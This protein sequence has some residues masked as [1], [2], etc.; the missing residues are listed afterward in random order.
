MKKMQYWYWPLL[1]L[2]GGASA[3]AASEGPQA[4]D[5][6]WQLPKMPPYPANNK[7]NA[8]RILLGKTLFFDPRLSKNGHMACATCHN[9]IQG[10]SDA[11]PV[12]LGYLGQALT[13]AAPSVM[14][15]AY[16]APLT[17]D[18]RKRD[19]EHQVTG[20]I[21]NP[22]E[23]AQD[24]GKLVEWLKTVSGYRILFAKAYPGEDISADTLSR[25]VASYE[26]TIVSQDSPFDQW[27]R[28]DKT[29]LSEQQL[30]GFKVFKDAKK[31]NCASCH[32]PPNFTDHRFH[33]VG[34][35]SH[36][37]E[38]ADLGRFNITREPHMKGAFK[39]PHLRNIALTAP[40]FHDGSAKTLE[41]VVEHFDRGGALQTPDL[42]P[43][44]KPLA[45]SHQ[46]KLDLVAFL[47]SLT[48]PPKPV[49]LP[50]LP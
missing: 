26:R 33:N 41:E 23:M 1:L 22:M 20:P 7:P 14:N 28:G 47:E 45:L 24:V 8:D 31:G 27:L 15:A 49:T 40:Y 13:R 36:G 34:L 25:G 3:W 10:W 43:Q 30:R 46:E 44:V 12:T 6:V 38:G 9:P 39:T 5:K 48:S 19:L 11:L 21:E 32:Q 4:A 42:S 2:A 17:W 50:S 37:L 29:A 16:N 35:A 18:G